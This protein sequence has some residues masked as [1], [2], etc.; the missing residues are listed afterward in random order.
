MEKDLRISLLN[1]NFVMIQICHIILV[2]IINHMNYIQDNI[3]KY[4]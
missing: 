2:L 3:F 1:F 4:F